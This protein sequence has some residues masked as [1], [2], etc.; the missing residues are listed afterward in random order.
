MHLN[1]TTIKIED[2]KKID[3]MT[4]KLALTCPSK[5]KGI[6]MLLTRKPPKSKLF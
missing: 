5:R 6:K 1:S 2:N 4:K 3:G